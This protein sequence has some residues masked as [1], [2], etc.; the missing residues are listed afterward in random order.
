[1]VTLLR[2][3]PG[4]NEPFNFVLFPNPTT[5]REARVLLS[6]VLGA[7][8]T[9]SIADLSG[10]NLLRTNVYVNEQ[11]I[12]ETFTCNCDI[13]VYLVSVFANGRMRSKPLVISR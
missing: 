3:Q 2:E 5:N 6:D 7:E 1:V 10:K 4:A 9:L 11:G 12:S 13:G 8:V